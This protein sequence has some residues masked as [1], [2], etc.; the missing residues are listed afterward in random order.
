MS[1]VQGSRDTKMFKF[2]DIDF[3]RIAVAAV[4]ALILTTTVVTAAVGPARA[5]ETEKVVLAAAS[6]MEEARG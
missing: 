4:G 1:G 3:Q 2:D 6:S 5:V